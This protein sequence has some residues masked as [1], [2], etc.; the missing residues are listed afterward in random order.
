MPSGQDTASSPGRQRPVLNFRS[1]KVSAFP[2]VSM[3]AENDASL[4]VADAG[5]AGA[6]S[7][8]AAKKP[9]ATETPATTPLR[10]TNGGEATPTTHPA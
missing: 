7:A 2:R 10:H 5:G 4:V 1:R 3:Q 9:E 8:D 6:A